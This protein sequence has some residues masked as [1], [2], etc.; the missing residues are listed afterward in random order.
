MEPIITL[1]HVSKEFK[2]LNRREGLKGSV[3]DLFSRDYKIVKAVNDVSMDIMPGEIC[4]YLGPNGAGKSTTI[5]IM[6]GILNPSSGECK[7]MGYTPWL[8]RK[9]YVKNIGVVFGQRSQLW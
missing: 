8:D 6:S 2:V 5:K 9:K 7:I 1:N 4:G 3:M